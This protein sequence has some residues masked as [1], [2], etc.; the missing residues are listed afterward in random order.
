MSQKHLRAASPT[1]AV[2]FA[3]V[4]ALVGAHPL[5]A[6]VWPPLTPEE[7]AM[8]D[9]PQQPGAE[10]VWL[11]R[12]MISDHEAFETKIF[13]RMKILKDSGRGHANIEIPYY[14]GR[15]KVEDLE[16]RHIPPQGEPVP[17]K[18]QVFDKTAVRYRRF[19]VAVKTFAVPDVAVGSIIEFRFR[20]VPDSGGSSG[21]D[22]ADAAENLSLFGSKPEE[23]G[24]PKIK[25]FLS[26]PA[27]RWEVQDDLFTLKARFEYSGHPYIW[28]LFDGPCRLTWVSHRLENA[29]PVIKGNRVELELANIPAFEDEELMT[30]EEAEQMSVDVS[31][32][33]R[34]ISDSDDFWKRESQNWQRAAEKFIGDPGKAAASAKELIGDA[35]DSVLKLGRLYDGVQKIRNLSYEKGLTR[36]QRKEQ[37]LKTNGSVGDVLERG[38]GVRSD[39]TRTFIALA[40]AAGF[41]AEAVR[42]STRDD[43]LFRINLLSFYDQMDSEVAMVNLGDRSLLFDPATPLCPFG[44]IHWSRS[45]TAGLRYSDKPPSFFTTTVYQPDLALT[46]REIALRLDPQGTFSGTV[47]TTYTGHEALVRKLEHLHDDAEASKKDLEKELADL[48]PLGAVVTLTKL[49]NIDNNAPNVIAGYEVSIPGIG[50]AAGEKMLIPVSPLVGAARYPFRHAER[51]YPVYF[52]YPFREFDDIVITL[53]EG[54]TAEVRPSPR[55]DQ[56]DFSAF[57]LASAVE[58]LGKIHIQRDLIIKKSLFP[59]EQYN[60][61][62]ALFDSVRAS[63]E[64]QIILTTAKK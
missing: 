55:K 17:F 20:I 28:T 29:K 64:A 35:A 50:T 49:E 18:G 33:D 26:F 13:K 15:A 3:I 11:Y 46:Q 22:E 27:I 30:P 38:Y 31:Y 52:P 2:L 1:V 48:L 62:K 21:R 7:K 59:V 40:R 45:N 42:V 51:R 9:C 10:A 34:R 57:S 39:I 24:L 61:L 4:M 43:K 58:G 60:D 14:A 54:L 32:L 19:R 36:K 16:I 53:P 41:Q 47:K 25:D 8:T 6:Q 5:S 12:E 56:N 23:G 44:L 63:D 37:K